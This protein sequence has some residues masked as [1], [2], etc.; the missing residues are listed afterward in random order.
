MTLENDLASGNLYILT[1]RKEK[2]GQLKLSLKSCDKILTQ[3]GINGSSGGH[4]GDTL[5]SLG[6]S[7]CPA[8]PIFGLGLSCRESPHLRSC[9]S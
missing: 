5:I 7:H 6:K 8:V 3:H 4:G 2:I 1:M 9:P